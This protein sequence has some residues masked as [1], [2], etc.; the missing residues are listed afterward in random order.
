MFILVA[1]ALVTLK[2]VYPTFIRPVFDYRSQIAEAR[3]QL[4]E[5][6]LEHGEIEDRCRK[7]YME[8][9]ARSGGTD[10]NEIRDDVWNVI[11]KDLISAAKLKGPSVKPKQPVQYRKTE[12]QLVRFQVDA[13]GQWAQCIDFIKRFYEIP[14]VARFDDLKLTPRASR[15]NVQQ[16]EVKLSAEIEVL[17]PPEEDE[18]EAA[19]E[20]LPTWPPKHAQVNYKALADARVFQIHYEAPPP[21]PTPQPERVTR[22]TEDPPTPPQRGPTGPPIDTMRGQKTIRMALNYGSAGTQVSEVLVED[23]RGR[24]SD[25]VAVGEELDR[26][27]LVLVHTLGAVAHKTDGDTDYGYFVYPLGETLASAVPLTEAQAWPEIQAAMVMWLRDHRE[28][29]EQPADEGSLDGEAGPD[30]QEPGRNQD[31][32]WG[33][34]DLPNDFVGPPYIKEVS[35]ESPKARAMVGEPHTPTDFVGPPRPRREA[36]AGWVDG[37]KDRPPAPEEAKPGTANQFQ[38]LLEAG[39]KKLEDE[40]RDGRLEPPDEGRTDDRSADRNHK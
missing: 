12:S 15:G 16:D 19:T 29:Q 33:D 17:V 31:W 25:Y 2:F 6:E 26:G 18:F 4:Y 1:V 32:E 36:G 9:L 11:Y 14:Y 38:Q 10:A 23:A 28:A 39:L 3:D 8:Y 40:E 13:E 22:A 35:L 24:T 34:F 37:T 27:R 20:D 5:L 30:S 7:A 21:R